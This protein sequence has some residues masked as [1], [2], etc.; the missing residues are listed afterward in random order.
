M[1]KYCIC[2]NLYQVEQLVEMLVKI[3][4]LCLTHRYIII[5]ISKHI[6]Y[7]TADLTFVPLHFNVIIIMKHSSSVCL[8]LELICSTRS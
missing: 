2:C 1:N 8:G 3:M 6:L 5:V 4:L 7:V